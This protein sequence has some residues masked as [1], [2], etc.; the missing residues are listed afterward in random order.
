MR[1]DTLSFLL[2]MANIGPYSDVLVV[3]MAGGLVVGAAAERL[4]GKLCLCLY[5]YSRAPYYLHVHLVVSGLG[6]SQ[7]IWS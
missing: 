7:L 4:G 2:S 6:G 1:F 5:Y 3:D